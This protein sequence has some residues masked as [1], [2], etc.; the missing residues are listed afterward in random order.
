M[1]SRN[2]SFELQLY[3]RV[4][5][6]LDSTSIASSCTISLH[7]YKFH[8]RHIRLFRGI[9]CIIK[10]FVPHL[11]A[12][13]LVSHKATCNAWGSTS[14]TNM[15]SN[16]ISNM[17]HVY[18]FKLYHDQDLSAYLFQTLICELHGVYG[19]HSS[20]SVHPLYTV[21]KIAAPNTQLHASLHQW[22]PNTLLKDKS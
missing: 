11:P 9:R 22:N 4:D 17:V 20:A 13:Y 15:T 8:A 5:D 19:F 3:S 12:T 7:I 21:G 10:L 16:V 2:L 1:P 6:E 14:E 18:L